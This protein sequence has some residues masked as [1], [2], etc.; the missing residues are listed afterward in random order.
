MKFIFPCVFILLC[1]FM[2]QC[3][4]QDPAQVNTVRQEIYNP[5]GDSE[6]ALLMRYMYDDCMRVKED[7]IMGQLSSIQFDPQSIFTAHATEPEKAASDT[8]KEMGLTYLA[9]HEAFEAAPVDQRQ[10]YFQAMVVTCIACHKQICP[11]PVSKISKL[12][13]DPESF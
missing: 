6:L 12:Y 7:L 8:Y 2:S 13:L 5:N 3:T 11:G 9:A 1:I 10:E 4:D